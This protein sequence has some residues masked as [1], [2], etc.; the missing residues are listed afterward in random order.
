MNTKENVEV[1]SII[2]V[3]VDE[4]KRKGTGYSLYSAK[5]IEIPEVESPEKLITLELLAKDNKKSLKYDVQDALLKYTITDGI[6]GTA[7]IILKSDYDGFTLYGFKGD[8]LMEKNALADIDEWKGQ[9]QEINKIYDY[10]TIIYIDANLDVK[11][12]I[13]KEF[14]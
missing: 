7:D 4:V 12:K 13:M 11:S 6:H 8:A 5:V 1:G 14:I 9:L 3:K 2:R 10:P